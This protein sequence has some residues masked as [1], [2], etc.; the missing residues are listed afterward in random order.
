M[1]EVYHGS[2]TTVKQPLCRAGRPNL[3]FGR[4]FYVTDIKKQ[5]IDW[6]MN[7]SRRTG[8]KPLLNIYQLDRKT[9]LSEERC[10]I[11][12]AY[13]REWLLFIVAARRG[14]DIASS[15]DYVEGGVANDRVIDT[16]NLYMAGLMGINTALQ[17]LSM[18]RP[19]NQMC[20]LS[21]RLIDKYL[22]YGGT[23]EI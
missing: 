9:I 18:H 15:Y 6:A 2:I 20:L 4:G 22:I 17:R 10:K 12:S 1:I 13:D 3:D 23:T 5:A 21:Q 11:F 8:E 19:N 16:V 14:A 7:M